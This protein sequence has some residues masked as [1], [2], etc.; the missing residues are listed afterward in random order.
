LAPQRSY[1]NVSA[2]TPNEYDKYSPIH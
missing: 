2:N 1:G